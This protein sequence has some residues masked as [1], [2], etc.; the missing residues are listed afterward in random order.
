MT[1]NGTATAT[2]TV[3][4]DRYLGM[5]PASHPGR[6]L[7]SGCALPREV[8]RSPI[9]PFDDF[10]WAASFPPAGRCSGPLPSCSSP[11]R[12][13]PSRWLRQQDGTLQPVTLLSHH[14]CISPLLRGAGSQATTLTSCH[15]DSDCACSPPA[16]AI[17]AFRAI[18]LLR[19][20]GSPQ[21]ITTTVR[22]E[23]LPRRTVGRAT[24]TWAY[25]TMK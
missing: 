10:F 7:R 16:R 13:L 23:S 6:P 8:G 5:R 2:M 22:E 24:V 3:N 21:F 20:G 17:S 9:Q 15:G 25:C 14:S 1:V 19:G 4:R 12:R 11:W 18:K